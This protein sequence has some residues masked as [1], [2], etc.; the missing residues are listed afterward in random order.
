MKRGKKL[1]TLLLVLVLLIGAALAA[2]KLTPDE[3]AGTEEN[4][5][6][7]IFTLDVDAV[8]QISWTYGEQTISFTKSNETWSY[9]NDASFPLNESY[10]ESALSSLSQIN[11][12]KTITS[13]ED[14][15]Q[16]GLEPPVCSIQVCADTTTELFIG[17][18]SSLGGQRYLSLGDGNVYLVDETI[19]DNFSEDL[20][21]FVQKETIPS[22]GNLTSVRIDTVSQ[23]L[24]LQHLEDS[25]IAYSDN[26]EWFVQNGD[27]YLTLDT[28]L[29]GDLVGNI[30]GMSWEACVDYDA[31][32]HLADY[33]LDTPAATITVDYMETT[34]VQ[35]NETDED[36]NV[37]YEQQ[38]TAKTFT[39]EIGDYVDESCY[40]RIAGSKMVYRIDAA[41]ADA[42][43]DTTYYDLRPD[44]VLNMKWNTVT[45]LDIILD[46]ET[47]YV[48]KTTQEVT[49]DDGNTTEETVYRYNDA[50][51]ELG[52]VLD[53]ITTME[54]SGY[55][56]NNTENR[57][58]ELRIVFHRDAETFS[59]VELVFY[60]YNSEFCM[61]SLNGEA[62]LLVARQDVVC[63]V[64]SINALVQE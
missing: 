46:G 28:E 5:G 18:E 56:E 26:Y 34:Q 60:R 24:E 59:E 12:A 48:E 54:T 8:S 7:Q 2:L 32:D 55:G 17:D 31:A 14:L 64:E 22:M 23:S 47:Y 61:V 57:T 9:D 1:L 52:D 20:L 21:S 40:A 63:L 15:S 37:I 41:I 33:G 38:Q 51:I 4:T 3:E 53:T 10:L 58:E 43:C 25:G 44:E 45:G 6:I 11:A 49:D 30:T 39:L 29:T 27:G 35:T 13:P 62:G 19:L 42:M 16:Y 36:G 50:Q